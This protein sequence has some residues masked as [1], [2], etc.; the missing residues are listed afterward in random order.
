ME[1]DESSAKTIGPLPKWLWILLAWLLALLMR[2]LGYFFYQEIRR[3][4]LADAEK[5]RRV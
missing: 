3:G 1:D 4:K 5:H 2:L